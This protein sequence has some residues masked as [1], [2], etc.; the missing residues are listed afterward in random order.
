VQLERRSIDALNR[1]SP[2]GGEH[3]DIVLYPEGQRSSALFLSDVTSVMD[4][5]LI[6][7]SALAA[8]LAGRFATAQNISLPSYAVALVGGLLMGYGSRVSFG[9]NIG[10]LFT[11]TTLPSTALTS[12]SRDWEACAVMASVENRPAAHSLK[13]RDFNEDFLLRMA[14]YGYVY[15]TMKRNATWNAAWT[16]G[17]VR[18]VSITAGYDG[19][20]ANAL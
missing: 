3:A 20:W 5:G 6:L 17:M 8:A 1:A 13:M 15:T 11:V 4:F 14:T 16:E 9:C 10:A 7:G 2:A 12:T 19:E 18:N